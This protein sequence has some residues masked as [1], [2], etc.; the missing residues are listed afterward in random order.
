MFQG[1]SKFIAW[2]REDFFMMH[3]CLDVFWQDA[4]DLSSDTWLVLYSLYLASNSPLDLKLRIF[5][6]RSWIPFSFSWDALD[7]N[8]CLATQLLQSSWPVESLVT[9]RKLEFLLKTELRAAEG[10]RFNVLLCI[11]SVSIWCNFRTW[12]YTFWRL[13]LHNS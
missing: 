12:F 1:F 3:N 11:Y 13:K 6:N 7:L 8:V 9:D 2:V 10:P 5:R 4:E